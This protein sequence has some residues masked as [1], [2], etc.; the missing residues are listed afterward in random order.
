MSLKARRIFIVEDK[1]IHVAIASVYLRYEGAIVEVHT[2]GMNVSQKLMTHLPIDV[3]LMDLVLSG[4]TSGFDVFDEIRQVP[5]LARIPVVAVSAV[6]PELAVPLARQKGFAGFISKPISS[7]IVQRV[8][9]VL[10]GKTVWET[11]SWQLW[12]REPF[13]GPD[14]HAGSES[15]TR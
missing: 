1:Y 3:V 8:A 12:L 11:G 7:S 10:A 6:D 13:A 14:H 4:H 15:K 2:Q 9:D 5:E